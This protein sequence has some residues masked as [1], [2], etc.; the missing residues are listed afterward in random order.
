MATITIDIH[1]KGHYAVD[2][3]QKRKIWN[4]LL[5]FDTSV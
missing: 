3:R 2:L 1:R 5:L 4:G